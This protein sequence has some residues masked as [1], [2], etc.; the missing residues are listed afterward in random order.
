MS[1]KIYNGLLLNGI[2]TLQDQHEFYLRARKAVKPAAGRDYKK[3]LL[4]S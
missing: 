4:R 1:T 3:L 2:H